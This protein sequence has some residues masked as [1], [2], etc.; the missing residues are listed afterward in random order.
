[1]LGGNL[2][3]VKVSKNMKRIFDMSGVSRIIKVYSDE[4]GY[5]ERVI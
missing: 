5:D 2:E 3:I 4:E 1:M